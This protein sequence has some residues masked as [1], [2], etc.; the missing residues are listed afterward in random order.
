VEEALN[1]RD[2]LPGAFTP[3]VMRHDSEGIVAPDRVTS[4]WLMGPHV[5][6]LRRS[7]ARQG[8]PRGEDGEGAAERRSLLNTPEAHASSQ[9]REA[10]G[11]LGGPG[12]P[13]HERRTLY[14]HVGS[15][16]LFSV[17]CQPTYMFVCA[18]S[19]AS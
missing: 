2:L 11:K 17:V 16:P 14:G 18:V 12:A 15:S 10:S 1:D 5:W 19:R 6:S 8:E 4:A 13:L 3:L 7:G 9:K